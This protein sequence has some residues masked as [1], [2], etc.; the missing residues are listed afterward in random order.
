MKTREKK[1]LALDLD[2]TLFNSE[3]MISLRTK[4]VL[5]Q[6][7]KEG[8]VLVLASGR[9]TPGVLPLVNELEM[10]DYGGY[11]LTFNGGQIVDC[12]TGRV[13]YQKTLPPE[14]IPELFEM[15]DKLDIAL[16]SYDEKGVVA[17][18]PDK[19][20]EFEASI[21]KLSLQYRDDIVEYLDFPLKKC[22]GA[23]N[24][25]YAPKVEQAYKY[26]FGDKVNVFRSEP[27]FIEITP[28]EVDKA[29]SLDRFCHI[30]GNRIENLIA[31]GDGFND[32]SM[33]RFAGMG[34]AMGNAQDDVKAVA[35]Y[36]TDTNDE[37]GVAKVVEEFILNPKSQ[38]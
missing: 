17:N 16:M 29:M 11:V 12:R 1:V 32:V 33:I 14:I 18:H 3:K 35:D 13:I 8:H 7:Q 10:A 31:C 26:S 25:E 24:P 4:K 5:I 6:M 28:P 30:T 36:I 38:F 15:A 21:N 27:F 37:D 23:A 19:Y 2:G 9:P 22:L 20:I 34:V